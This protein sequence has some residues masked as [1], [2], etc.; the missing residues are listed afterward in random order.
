VLPRGFAFFAGRYPDHPIVS[1]VDLDYGDI[2]PDNWDEGWAGTESLLSY[3]NS[4]VFQNYTYVS[5]EPTFDNWRFMTSQIPFGDCEEFAI[6]QAQMLLERGV[7]VENLQLEV[8]IK[9][10]KNGLG[11]IIKRVGH[12]WLV[13]YGQALDG[14]ITTRESMQEKYPVDG[15]IQHPTIA[16]R[17]IGVSNSYGDKYTD[18]EII[19]E[20][21]PYPH[22]PF[23]VSI[24]NFTC[25]ISR[26]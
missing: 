2:N 22:T 11:E 17:W 1:R 13:A 21:E 4:Y 23:D 15:K 8:G 12:A 25:K 6:T 16:N 20:E 14:T 19:L 7:P 9:V 26:V 24:V 10:T 3:V 18:E 5:E